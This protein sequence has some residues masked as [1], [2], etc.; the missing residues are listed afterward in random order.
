MLA[1]DAVAATHPCDLAF[2]FFF[3]LSVVCKIIHQVTLFPTYSRI[4]A[5]NAAQRKQ[6]FCNL[7][8][9]MR[10]C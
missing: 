4:G 5:G 10:F 1:A 6:K 7:R 3:K 9:K 8:Q 2:F